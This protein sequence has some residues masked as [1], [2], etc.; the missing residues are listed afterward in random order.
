MKVMMTMIITTMIKIMM[1]LRMMVIMTK[2]M[3]MMVMMILL[4]TTFAD[5]F[6]MLVK[7]TNCTIV[8]Y[9]GKKL[10]RINVKGQ[11]CVFIMIFKILIL[12]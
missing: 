11:E 9:M 12:C 7:F 6:C 8:H 4:L 5:D 3:Q 2:M 10:E 1:K